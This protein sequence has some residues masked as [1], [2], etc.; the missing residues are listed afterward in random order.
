[1]KS[2]NSKCIATGLHNVLR[3]F[4]LKRRRPMRLPASQSCQL[5]DEPIILPSA[6]TDLI[7]VSNS[8]RGFIDCADGPRQLSNNTEVWRSPSWFFVAAF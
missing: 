7:I 4:Q 1:M 3:D 6:Q 5:F 2:L 8:P